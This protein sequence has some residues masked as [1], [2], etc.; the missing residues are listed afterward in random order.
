MNYTDLKAAITSFLNN[1]EAEFTA[2]RDTFI[3]LGE[4]RI[5]TNFELPAAEKNATSTTTQSDR[6]LSIPSDVISISTLSTVISNVHAP[7]RQKGKGFIREAYPNVSS[8]AEGTP[9]FYE[10]Y[11]HN[12]IQLGPVPDAS[13]SVELTYQGVPT[14]IVSASTTW[15]GDNFEQLLLY[16]SLAEGYIFMKGDADLLAQY[17]ARYSEEVLKVNAN[18][19]KKAAGGN[20]YER[21]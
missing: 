18:V 9:V 21:A 10:V 8:S 12:S 7:I 13:I 14:S 16:A 15:L 4:R 17:E 3:K 5:Y 20:R 6:F 1:T 19:V 2:D 11:D